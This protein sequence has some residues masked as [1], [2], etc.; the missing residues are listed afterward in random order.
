MIKEEQRQE[1]WL[2]DNQ[3]I[4]NYFSSLNV[5]IL[6]LQIWSSTILDFMFTQYVYAVLFETWEELFCLVSFIMEE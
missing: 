5:I 4:Y 1:I 3:N 6:D 2:N